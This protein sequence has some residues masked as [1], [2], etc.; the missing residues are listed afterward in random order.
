MSSTLKKKLHLSPSSPGLTFQ[1]SV[2]DISLDLCP[3]IAFQP[4]SVFVEISRNKKSRCSSRSSWEASLKS[5]HHGF[6]FWEPAFV[7]EW[8]VNVSKGKDRK[9]IMISVYNVDGKGKK[10]LLV[11]NKINLLDYRQDQISPEME[12]ARTKLFPETKKVTKCSLA[13]TVVPKS[14]AALDHDN[15]EGELETEKADLVV[16]VMGSV[17]SSLSIRSSVVDG[18]E[19]KPE[20]SVSAV[21]S[22]PPILKSQKEV[23]EEEGRDSDHRE[24]PVPP[25]PDTQ[26]DVTIVT[27]G[28]VESAETSK[29]DDTA[30]KMSKEEE[31]K[32]MSICDKPTKE[33][34]QSEANKAKPS[35][36]DGQRGLQ[37]EVTE[38][39]PPRQN[40]RLA[41]TTL[42]T[43]LRDPSPSSN[44]SFSKDR[45]GS[46]RGLG[47]GETSILSWAR[48]VL[49]NYPQVKVT[50][51][52]LTTWR[53]GY[54]FCSLIHSSYPDLIPLKDLTSYN[55][56]VNCVL[57]FE[58][59]K[60]IGVDLHS[61]PLKPKFEENRLVDSQIISIFLERLRPR[62]EAPKSF[63]EEEISQWKRKCFE[64]FNLFKQE[65]P[66]SPLPMPPQVQAAQNNADTDRLP[67]T[68]SRQRVKDLISQAHY[69]SSQNGK[70]GGSTQST[71]SPQEESNRTMVRMDTIRNE[72]QE[73][74]QTVD[75]I[76]HEQ[77]ILE[78]VLRDE[79]DDKQALDRLL[80]LV[81]EKNAV[82]RRQMQ[83]NILQK[84][85]EISAR[86]QRIQSELQD[87]AAK[88]DEDKTEAIREREQALLEEFLSLVD[89]K[90]ELVHHLDTQEE[91]IKVDE[92]IKVDSTQLIGVG[93]A[94]QKEECVIQ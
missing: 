86:Q 49:Q 4:N 32:N 90:N 18:E 7:T 69:Q 23:E 68:P 11:R 19:S 70:D 34:S 35:F 74:E 57:A 83:L 54:G 24:T 10:K 5:P 12:Q 41:T 2:R 85:R 17:A 93:G 21:S 14:S 75:Q 67:L 8:T 61:P 13:M 26:E 47:T 89:Q 42:Q 6:C 77:T 30:E 59:S 82:V 71:G 79:S 33:A 66:A 37:E 36:E 64:S 53:N 81:N 9:E 1:V 62:L 51:N 20:S 58:A 38:D 39:T 43:P 88:S 84:E 76:N 65:F 78:R 3:G 31:A 50:N 45:L 94:G 40:L 56:E 27:G 29:T 87:L 55:A 22:S 46:K 60:L 73:L 15:N 80:T 91:A 48:R 92:S 25:C 16:P 52:W 63:T 72:L 44:L 28:K